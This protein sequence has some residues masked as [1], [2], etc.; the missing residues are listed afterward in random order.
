MVKDIEAGARRIDPENL[1][2]F[3]PAAG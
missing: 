2:S 3:A 1:A